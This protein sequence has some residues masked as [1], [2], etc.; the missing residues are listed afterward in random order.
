MGR[1]G[2]EERRGEK[3]ALEKSVCEVP[4]AESAKSSRPETPEEKFCSSLDEVKR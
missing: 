3:Y 4:P 1:W 2:G